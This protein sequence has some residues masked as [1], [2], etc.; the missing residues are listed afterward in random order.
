MRRR[1]FIT[2]L[3][4]AAVVWPLAA[5]GQSTR[6]VWRLGWLTEAAN[7]GTVFFDALRELGYTEDQNLAVERRF[8]NA[9]FERL[10]ALATEL[11]ALKLDVIHKARRH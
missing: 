11:V 4:G 6:K 7:T 2:L 1:E 10:P 8:A 9:K 5:K 3:A